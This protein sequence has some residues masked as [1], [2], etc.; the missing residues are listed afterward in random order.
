MLL[1]AIIIGD[2][3]G[4]QGGF[5]ACGVFCAVIDSRGI[6]IALQLIATWCKRKIGCAGTRKRPMVGVGDINISFSTTFW[7]RW[8][9]AMVFTAIVVVYDFIVNIRANLI[10]NGIGCINWV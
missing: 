5:V 10:K 6:R 4:E 1:G 7:F 8:S 3:Q 2:G 9:C